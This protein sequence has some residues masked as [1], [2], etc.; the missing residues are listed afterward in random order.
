MTNRIKGLNGW[1]GIMSLAIA[2]FHFEAHYIQRPKYFATG[3]LVVEFFFAISGFLL[4][5]SLQKK[6]HISLSEEIKKKLSRLYPLYLWGI[7]AMIILHSIKWKNGDILKWFT[8]DASPNLIWEIFML[9]RSG[10][11]TDNL[12]NY[13]AWYI[14]A[15]MI[16][17]CLLIILIKNNKKYL[18]FIIAPL[19]VLIIYPLLMHKD[20]I[21]DGSAGFIYIFNV[22]LLRAW[23]G[24]CLGCIIFSL[25]L[26]KNRIH[27]HKIGFF[28]L[29]LLMFSLLLRLVIYNKP[30][31]YDFLVLIPISF[32][33]LSSVLGIGIITKILSLSPFEK[34]GKVSFSIF[35]NHSLVISAM[36]YYLPALNRTI[37]SAV[38]LMATILYSLLV[39]YVFEDKFPAFISKAFNR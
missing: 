14:S 4:F 38:F 3:Y 17:S 2:M 13:P 20:G 10:I 31:V 12:V 11:A 27:Q 8:E 18:Q 19:S 6:E 33:L 24:M 21:L 9:Q 36:T 25:S 35:I 34:L 22:G 30:S 15:L 1:K 28:F 37:A 16:A 7:F 32:F 39:K 5:Y 26:Q 23:A 29:E